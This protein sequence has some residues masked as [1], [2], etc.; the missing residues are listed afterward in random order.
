MT[1]NIE[2]YL[3][4]WADRPN[5]PKIVRL[6]I[7]TIIVFFFYSCWLMW[8]V[9]RWPF[10]PDFSTYSKSWRWQ[11]LSERETTWQKQKQRS[12]FVEISC[13]IHPFLSTRPPVYPPVHPSTHTPIHPYTHPPLCPPVLPFRQLSTLP[14]L[15][16]PIHPY[17]NLSTRVHPTKFNSTRLI[18]DTRPPLPPLSRLHR[19]P[20]WSQR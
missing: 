7:C 18:L 2:R 19:P 10:F 16:P 3:L 5:L 6:R 20:V 1:M 12:I 4:P 11:Y 13:A 8:L 9:R 14:P 15:K 17:L